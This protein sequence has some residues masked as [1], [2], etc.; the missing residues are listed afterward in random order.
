MSSLLSS[1][2]INIRQELLDIVLKDLRGPA[3]GPEEIIKEQTVRDRYVL[4][5]LAP[6]GQTPLPAE[7]DED[8][9]SDGMDGEDGKNLP[10]GVYYYIFKPSPSDTP[11]KGFVQIYR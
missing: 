7:E 9:A 2:P 3:E 8:I 1:S 6:K 4:G 11:L 10:D 5:L